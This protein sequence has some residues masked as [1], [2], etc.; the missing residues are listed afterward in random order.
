MTR[1][2]ENSRD[3][4]NLLAGQ[5]GQA[6]AIDPRDSRGL[7]NA[8]ISRVR[9][10]AILESLESMPSSTSV[11]DFGSGTG[12]FL[13][14]LRSLYP[15]FLATGTDISLVMLRHAVARDPALAGSLFLYDGEA[16]PIKS[17]SLDV[18]TTGGVLLYFR[19]EE[20]FIRICREFQ[21]VLRPGGQVIAVE[22]VCR[23]TRT[24][25]RN[26][27]VQRSPEEFQRLFEKCGFRSV[28]WRQLRRARFPLV[29]AIRYGLVPRS[30][31][32]I[33]AR[34]E[35]WLW[36]GPRLPRLDY[37]DAVFRFVKDAHD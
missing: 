27:K 31:H 7:K 26:M 28:S 32:G 37:A 3:F 17:E 34:L 2:T 24:D 4:W 21:R 18:I 9:D 35:G 15:E 8:Y 1:E 20:D 33:I 30:L 16:L 11:L 6:A 23:R 36:S 19:E 13:S 12:T 10:A 5:S 22:Q 14:K 29:Y 25:A